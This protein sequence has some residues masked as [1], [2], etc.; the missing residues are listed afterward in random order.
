MHDP[1]KHTRNEDVV[2]VATSLGVDV[3][4]ADSACS[5]TFDVVTYFTKT[6]PTRADEDD[7]RLQISA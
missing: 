2:R 3:D 7:E 1:I 6:V 4:N 5:D